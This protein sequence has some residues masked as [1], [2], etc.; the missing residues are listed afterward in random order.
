VRWLGSVDDVASVEDFRPYRDRWVLTEVRRYFARPSFPVSVSVSVLAEREDGGLR[1][2]EVNFAAGPGVEGTAT[3]VLPVSKPA[4]RGV[5]LAHG[6][7]DDGRR[8]FLSEAAALAAQ[9]AAVIL[10]VM[11]IRQDE[12]VDAFAA[13][14]RIAV[15]IECAALDVLVEVG[16]PP[17]ALSFL[18]HSAGG[19]LGA[20]LS[21]VEPR[22]ARIVIFAN[23]AGPLARSAM[24]SGF[25]RGAEVTE[26]LA[27][28]A[29]W[30]D[31]AHFVG[32]DRC[33][34]L[35][36]QQGRADQT[37]PM[38]AG[39]ALFDA[40]AQPKLWAEYDWDHGLDADPQARGD[41]AD[42]VAGTPPSV[43]TSG[44]YTYRTWR[45]DRRLLTGLRPSPTRRAGSGLLRGGSGRAG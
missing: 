2:R 31:L 37:V 35:L 23:G 30:F 28:V 34:Q 43:P 3:M 12:G 20:I 21:A 29:D 19:A 5:V 18:G 25:S 9:G 41:R 36:I 22:L 8:F 27:A 6:G 11:R 7:S 10:P 4:M 26:D 38:A 42:F 17:G 15:L 33:A 13:D 45:P 32:V 40:A 39:R 16:A 14:V 1:W 24:A 44:G